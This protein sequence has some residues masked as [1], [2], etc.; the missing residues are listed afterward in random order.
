MVLQTTTLSLA[1]LVEMV[2]SMPRHRLQLPQSR[3]RAC[4]RPLALSYPRFLA[5]FLRRH[6]GLEVVDLEARLTAEPPLFLLMSRRSLALV[7]L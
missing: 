5:G 7:H 4:P 3:L 2:P 1:A 6:Q